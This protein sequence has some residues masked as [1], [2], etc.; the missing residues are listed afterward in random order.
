MWEIRSNG[1]LHVVQF[2]GIS[3]SSTF[4]TLDT[5]KIPLSAAPFSGGPFSSFFLTIGI[6]SASFRVPSKL[7]DSL[8]TTRSFCCSPWR[9]SCS[10]FVTIRLCSGLSA[11]AGDSGSVKFDSE[12]DD[13]GASR[14]TMTFPRAEI[15]VGEISAVKT[16][17]H[18]H[19]QQSCFRALNN[20]IA[21]HFSSRA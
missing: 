12:L 18:N 9:S 7:I 15:P 14:I 16:T 5:L 17:F 8:W 6:S 2:I 4:L 1:N 11:W 19:H 10:N 20:K 3:D 21:S 13:V